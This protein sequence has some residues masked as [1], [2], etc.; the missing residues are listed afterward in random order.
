M[1]LKCGHEVATGADRFQALICKVI[2]FKNEIMGYFGTEEV[3][4]G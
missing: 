4:S 2:N 1:G 3:H